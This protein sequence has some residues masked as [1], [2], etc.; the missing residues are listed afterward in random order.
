MRNQ[1]RRGVVAVIG[2]FIANW[3]ARIGHTEILGRILRRPE[4]TKFSAFDESLLQV[5][6][7]ALRE[8]HTCL[9]LASFATRAEAQ[10]GV[11]KPSPEAILNALQRMQAHHRI[12]LTDTNVAIMRCAVAEET[13]A[14]GLTYIGRRVR[15][16]H[17]ARLDQLI[18]SSIVGLSDEQCDAVRRIVN[19][20][21]S[22]LTG[23][24][25]T[26][27]T[28]TVKALIEIFEQSGCKVRLA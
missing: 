6:D 25:G 4:R 12:R 3:L 2:W 23:A 15:P 13:I 26:G 17:P 16:I 18:E 14:K 5:L 7:Q 11:S 19:A 8:G 1:L 28:S 20:P 22:I 9:S 24:P 27:K 10:L 21:V